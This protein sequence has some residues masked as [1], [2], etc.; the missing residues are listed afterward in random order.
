MKNLKFNRELVKLSSK[1]VDLYAAEI[2]STT[3]FSQ[4]MIAGITTIS[5]S[6]QLNCEPLACLLHMVH[7]LC[8]HTV[9]LIASDGQSQNQRSTEYEL[10]VT[11][12]YNFP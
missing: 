7:V 6:L 10:E 11:W 3:D 12:K 9:L 5:P 1:E 2:G 8:T 4:A